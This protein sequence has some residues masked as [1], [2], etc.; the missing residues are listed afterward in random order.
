MDKMGIILKLIKKHFSFLSSH[1]DAAIA[2]E[3][4]EMGM[5]SVFVTYISKHAG[6]RIS[7]EATEGGIFVMIF[8]LHDGKIPEYGFWYDVIDYFR[9]ID[10][11]FIEKEITNYLN[12]DIYEIEAALEHFADSVETH[13]QSFL[14]GD[15]SKIHIMDEII[16][17]RAES[18]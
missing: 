8:P 9:S 11:K 3:E 14:Q 5:K 7:Y 6:I 16:K 2:K 13:I 12:P 4:T 10:V 18:M 1:F 17:K 15:F